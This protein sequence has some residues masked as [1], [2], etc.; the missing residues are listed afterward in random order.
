MKES[1]NSEILTRVDSF[2]LLVAMTFSFH[3]GKWQQQL[4]D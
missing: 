2:P 3:F 1:L 4:D